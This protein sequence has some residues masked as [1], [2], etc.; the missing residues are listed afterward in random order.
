MRERAIAIATTG[1][2]SAKLAAAGATVAVMAGGAI[3]ATQT[4]THPRRH[5]ARHVAGV[6]AS[7]P[8]VPVPA[9][10][11]LARAASVDDE[12][13]SGSR[14]QTT[15]R[16]PERREP[17]GF[18]FLGVPGGSAKPAAS[19]TAAHAASVGQAPAPPRRSA[20]LPQKG[21]G[22]FSP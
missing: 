6:A 20:A 21:G 17:G 1:G 2:V 8:R 3:G 12:G 7:T 4:P 18:A 9:S 15:V 13:R 19:A 16:R 10:V 22:P 5:R 14:A 11:A